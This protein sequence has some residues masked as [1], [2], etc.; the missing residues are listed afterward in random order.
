MRRN[1]LN[2]RDLSRIVRRVINEDKENDILKIQ[3]ALNKVWTNVK[4]KEDGVMGPQTKRTIEMYQNQM[5]M[6]VT[7][8]IDDKLKTK[9]FR[10]LEDEPK[11][12]NSKTDLIRILRNHLQSLEED[13]VDA[14]TVAEII[15]NDC[16]NFMNKT[17][18]F[19]DKTKYG[20]PYKTK[21]QF[22][23]EE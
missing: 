22:A 16:A 9:L 8:N 4:I 6:P 7:G 2:E 13:D 1:R 14:N 17:D 10:L 12:K 21:A 3:K 19:S 20:K 5:N 23:P 18:I 11:F 15:Y